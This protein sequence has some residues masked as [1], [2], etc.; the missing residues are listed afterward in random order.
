MRKSRVWG[1][2]FHV[3]QGPAF[4][5]T[6]YWM[7]DLNEHEFFST[8]FG[9]TVKAEP[10]FQHRAHPSLAAKHQPFPTDSSSDWFTSLMAMGAFTTHWLHWRERREKELKGDVECFYLFY[11]LRPVHQYGYNRVTKRGVFQSVK[12]NFE[13]WPLFMYLAFTRTPG[14]TVF[15]VV[16]ERQNRPVAWKPL[17]EWVT[18]HWCAW[19]Y[20]RV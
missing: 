15:V 20:V 17:P 4:S 12:T 9:T 7:P 10:P 13:D 1:F 3:R 18:L 5:T 2:M 14:E 16:F 6:Q 11:F 8:S 19:Q